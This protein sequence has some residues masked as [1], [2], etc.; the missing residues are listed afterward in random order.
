MP[1]HQSAGDGR[2]S[3]LKYTASDCESQVCA[4]GDG[5]ESPLKY[6]STRYLPDQPN[7][8]DGRESPLKYTVLTLRTLVPQR[9][10]MAGNRRSS[11]LCECSCT[12]SS[13]WGWP[14]IAAQVHS[15]YIEHARTERW[16]WPGIAA[17][18][19][20]DCRMAVY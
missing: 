10:G 3:P 17:Q 4:A 6:T 15:M 8:G 14:G 12:D 19:H 11:T 13:G 16:G 7:A 1:D 5:R 20:F 9:L 18:V 2:E